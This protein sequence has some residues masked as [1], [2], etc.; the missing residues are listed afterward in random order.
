MADDVRRWSDELAHDPASLAFLPLAETLRRQGQ[1]ELAR[2]VALRG[3]GRH[4]HNPEA[5]DLLARIHADL[6]DI[7]SAFD[8][9]DAVL[10]LAPD[11]LGA[12]K[13]MAFV[14]F[15]QGDHAE[16]ERL[17]LRAQ[18]AGGAHDAAV[19][20]AIQTVRRSSAMP[21]PVEAM[22]EDLPSDPHLLFR[23]LLAD[24]QTAMLLSKDGLVLAGAY[25]SADGRDVASEVGAS[26]SGV[27]DEAF[28]ATRHLEIGAWRSIIFETEAAVV[29]LSPAPADGAL[30]EGGLLVLAGATA[31]PLGLLRRLLDRCLARVSAWLASGGRARA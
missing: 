31:T 16:A 12:V 15:Q 18:T 26:L 7:Q 5:H 17:L 13:G 2:K 30:G 27:S 25:Y 20:A 6:G 29:S 14:R 8:E 21:I 19:S 11:H 10:R 4:P 23:D 28:R 22:A 1:L 24:D 3:L 9:W